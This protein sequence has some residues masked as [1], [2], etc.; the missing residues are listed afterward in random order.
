MSTNTSFR[1]VALVL[2]GLGVLEVSV[3]AQRRKP[4]TERIACSFEGQTYFPFGYYD[5][6]APGDMQ[7]VTQISYRCYEVGDQVV[8][9]R[10]TRRASTK[11]AKVNVEI[12]MSRGS[13]GTYDR[14]MRGVNDEVHYNIYLDPACTIIW[15]DGTGG[16]STHIKKN[17]EPS[18]SIQTIPVYGR[19][20]AGQNATG[21]AYADMIVITIDF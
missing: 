11:K 6:F 13:S 10:L 9:S 18:D 3:A 19:M 4:N 7:V 17:V 5:P 1:I 2:A 20:P 16:T 15:G 8:T 21:G 12:S 14:K